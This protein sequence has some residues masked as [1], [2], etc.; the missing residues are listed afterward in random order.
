MSL[1]TKYRP[2][3][4]QAVPSAHKAPVQSRWMTVFV[5][6]YL[7]NR[8]SSEI[9][10]GSV[11][12]IGCLPL[13]SRCVWAS[14]AGAN[15]AAAAER[16]VR[17]RMRGEDSRRCGFTGIFYYTALLQ[18]DELLANGV[19]DQFRPVVDFELPQ[20]VRL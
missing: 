9:K 3:P 16:N 11:Y 2:R 12:R 8:R 7:S 14:A 13:Q 5:I 10:S 4:F 1:Q 19:S 20:Q 18:G 6:R 15:A 17:R